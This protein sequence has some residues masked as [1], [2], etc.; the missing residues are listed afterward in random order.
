VADPFATY[1]ATGEAAGP[2]VVGGTG[3]A[4][5]AGGDVAEIPRSAVKM[6][7]ELTA[8]LRLIRRR[9]APTPP[10]DGRV[11]RDRRAGLGV[12]LCEP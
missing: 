7:L 1:V 4:L 3:Q 8:A 11:L 2:Y 9:D 12:V 6:Q 5:L 10:R